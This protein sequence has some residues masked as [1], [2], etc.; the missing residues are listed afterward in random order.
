MIQYPDEA[1]LEG[2][3]LR[4]DYIINFTFKV[5]RDHNTLKD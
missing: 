4:C 5:G 1:I 2:L 3:R